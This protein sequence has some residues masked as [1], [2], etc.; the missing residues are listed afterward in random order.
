[1]MRRPTKVWCCLPYRVESNIP[2]S[3]LRTRK[4]SW[5]GLG[6]ETTPVWRFLKNWKKT[7]LYKNITKNIKLKICYDLWWMMVGLYTFL[8]YLI[9]N[10]THNTMYKCR[11]QCWNEMVGLLSTRELWYMDLDRV[12]GARHYS[13]F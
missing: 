7:N 4:V 10:N 6:T 2:P 9:N 12:T 5:G 8:W 11:L 1:M 3:R 13:P